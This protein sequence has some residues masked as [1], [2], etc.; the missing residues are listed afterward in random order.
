MS[1][2]CVLNSLLVMCSLLQGDNTSHVII[3]DLGCN[4]TH[5]LSVITGWS[6]CKAI[7]STATMLGLVR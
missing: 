7:L 6:L 2:M 4:Y 3:R 5:G 1:C